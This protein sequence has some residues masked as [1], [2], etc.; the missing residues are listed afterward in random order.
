MALVGVK[1]KVDQNSEVRRM[2]SVITVARKGTTK[3]SVGI[4]RRKKK[5]KVLS[6]QKLKVVQQAP[7]MMVKFYTARQQQLLKAEEVSLMLGLWTQEQ[8][9]I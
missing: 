9:G 2:S 3:E 7:R 4:S 8:H 1:I 6:R 5:V